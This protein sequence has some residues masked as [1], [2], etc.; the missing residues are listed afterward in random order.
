MKKIL[1]CVLLFSNIYVLG[2]SGNELFKA[3][4]FS[5]IGLLNGVSSPIAGSVAYLTDITKM[6]YYDGSQWQ[7]IGGGNGWD[8][9][10]NSGTNSS[11][12]FLG[13]TDNNDFNIRTNNT[14][15]VRV[16]A[17][18]NF[19]VLNDLVVDGAAYSN[20]S[21]NAGSA[22]TINFQQSNLAYTNANAQNTF[23]LQN[24]KDGGTYTLSVRGT[25]AGTASFSAAGYSFKS[26]S[27]GKTIANTHTLYTFLVIGNIVYVNM[28]TGL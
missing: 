24:L 13:T 3:H 21:F 7:E 19:R 17:N 23:T 27:N 9:L 15:R 1:I 28:C 14:N 2:Q 6:M 4:D 12:N 8:L 5:N 10:G 25:S 11:V 22:T 26:T 16:E 20:T 18:G